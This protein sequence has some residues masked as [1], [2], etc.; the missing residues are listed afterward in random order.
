VG[1]GLSSWT[2]RRTRVIGGG[3]E[4][5]VLCYHAVSESW[6]ADLSVTT[7]QLREQLEL[8]VHRGYRSA[9]LH[10]AVT[11]PSPS[12]RTLVVT[13]DD[14]Y[15]SVLELA[16]PILNSLGIRGTVFAVTDFVDEDKPLDWPGIDHWRDGPHEAELRG[17]S[18]TQLEQLASA[19]WEIGSHTCTHPRLTQL[20]DAALACELRDSRAACERALGRACRSLAYPYGDFDARVAAAAE[21][22]GYE[23]AAT[24][25]ERLPKRSTALAWPRIGV[26]HPDS[27][28]RF[29]LKVSPTIRRLRTTFARAEPFVRA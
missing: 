18:W 4:V 27:L 2:T 7:A 6:P 5:L 9:T 12:R 28:G 16:H 8:L 1:P 3:A 22:A 21:E 19:G 13:F 14:A 17:L 20:D 23:T 26:Y 25:P 24:L 29:R 15:L 11:A 10:D